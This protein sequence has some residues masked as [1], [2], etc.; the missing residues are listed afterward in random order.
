MQKK[1]QEAQEK[2][3]K[4]REDAEQR[5][6]KLIEWIDQAK[7]PFIEALAN[8]ADSLTFLKPSEYVNLIIT[9]GPALELFRD[10]D[11]ADGRQVLSIQ[12]SWATDYKAGRLTLDAFKQKVLQYTN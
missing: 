10:S 2:M 1:V 11:S 8:H 5:R 9:A 3:K 12:K 6:K 4:R 7:G